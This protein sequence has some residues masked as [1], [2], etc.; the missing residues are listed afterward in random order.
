MP[1]A[2]D[3][4]VD[5]QPSGRRIEPDGEMPLA[6][7]VANIEVLTTGQIVVTPTSTSLQDGKITNELLDLLFELEERSII[8]NAQDEDM[9]SSPVQGKLV[10]A[11]KAGN[12][13]CVIASSETMRANF[14]ESNLDTIFKIVGTM[15]EALTLLDIT[16]ACVDHDQSLQLVDELNE[17]GRIRNQNS[18]L[19]REDSWSAPVGSVRD[20]SPLTVSGGVVPDSSEVLMYVIDS[21]RID[22][23]DVAVVNDAAGEVGLTATIAANIDARSEKTDKV[24]LDVSK[25]DRIDSQGVQELL[26][27]YTTLKVRSVELVVVDSSEGAAVTSLPV[28]EKML[29]RLFEFADDLTSAVSN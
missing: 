27:L 3:S 16:H 28:N 26:N 21:G 14:R 4:T 17:Q 29:D 25:A 5:F 8:M 10:A 9:M 7:G 22:S 19:H 1:S 15:N 13:C 12:L 6:L 24:V 11:N 2:D 20:S 23:G 18:A